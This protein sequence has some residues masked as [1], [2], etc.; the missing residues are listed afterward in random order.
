MYVQEIL[1]SVLPAV[2]GKQTFERN[3]ESYIVLEPLAVAMGLDWPT[4]YGA[5][6]ANPGRWEITVVVMDR[7]GD[8]EA[9]PWTGL[10]LRQLPAWLATIDTSQV[11]PGLAAWVASFQKEIETTKLAAPGTGIAEESSDLPESPSGVQLL[12]DVQAMA[13]DPHH[14]EA[15]LLEAEAQLFARLDAND[16]R[17]AEI[18]AELAELGDIIEFGGFDAGEGEMRTV[19]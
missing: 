4:V 6:A 7:V 17:I 12:Q 5:L 16:K 15:T 11:R 14:R 19:H 2:L 1:M 8:G 10:P 18:G 3:G 9:R 13:A